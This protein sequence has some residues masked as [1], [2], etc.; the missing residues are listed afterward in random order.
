[1]DILFED[2]FDLNKIAD[3]GQCFRWEFQNG[4][5]RF[6]YREYVLDIQQMPGLPDHFRVSCGAR[7]WEDIWKNYFDMNRNYSK[8]RNRCT[9]TQ[10]P[11]VLSSVPS[12]NGNRSAS[13]QEISSHGGNA[14]EVITAQTFLDRAV[15]AGTGIRILRQDPWEMLITFIISQRKNIPAIRK[16][17]QLL[18]QTYG[19][20]IGDTGSFSFP[21]PEDLRDVTAENLRELGLGYRAPYVR[22]AAQRVLDGRLNFDELQKLPDEE[23]FSELMQVEGVGKKVANCVC[24]FGF[25]RT[26]RSPVDVWISRAIDLCGGADP[27]PAFGD[28]AGIVQQYV[29]YFMKHPQR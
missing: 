27:F 29:F 13:N 14:C 28:A 22:C 21:L 1:M 11:L 7:E 5:Y 3:C 23:L 26:A 25:S 10:L 24:L 8:I 15:K 6:V 16:A 9:G 12:D 18:A 20:P 17:V 2:D 4:V 19:H